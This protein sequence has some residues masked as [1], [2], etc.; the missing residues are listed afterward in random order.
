MVRCKELWQ[1]E[2]VDEVMPEGNSLKERAA[3]RVT[4]ES[5]SVNMNDQTRFV[6]MSNREDL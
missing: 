1:H 3:K 4:A 5:R 6:T 2:H